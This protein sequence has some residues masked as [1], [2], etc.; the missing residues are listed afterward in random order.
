[1]DKKMEFIEMH[2][3]GSEVEHIGMCETLFPPLND[4]DTDDIVEVDHHYGPNV[5]I[6]HDPMENITR[7]CVKVD[8]IDRISYIF[9]MEIIRVHAENQDLFEYDPEIDMFHVI[10]FSV[11]DPLFDK[12]GFI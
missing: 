4:Y 11:F 10:N 12:Y 6:T 2:L 5:S 8:D 3:N 1:M 7:I 9:G